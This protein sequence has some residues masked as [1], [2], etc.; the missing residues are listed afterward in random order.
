MWDKHDET[1]YLCDDGCCVDLNG[2]F[3]NFASRTDCAATGGLHGRQ[4][5]EGVVGRL[6]ARPRK[7]RALPSLLVRRPGPRALHVIFTLR[8]ATPASPKFMRAAV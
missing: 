5:D 7:P 4:R 6:L 8:S 2:Y 1:D 3:R